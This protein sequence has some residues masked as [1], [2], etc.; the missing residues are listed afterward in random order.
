[1][2]SPMTVRLPAV[3]VVV[4]VALP[5]AVATAVA[6]EPLHRCVPIRATVVLVRQR[7]LLSV[8]RQQP[9]WWRKWLPNRLLRKL[10]SRL[11]QSRRC[12]QA[13]PV[14]VVQRL[15]ERPKA[16][17]ILSI[18]PIGSLESVGLLISGWS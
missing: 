7:Q 2:L 18:S 1:M 12:L 16:S 13:A 14:V 5:M 10:L 17:L 9:L 8:Q 15:A 4:A 11:P 6:V 3:A